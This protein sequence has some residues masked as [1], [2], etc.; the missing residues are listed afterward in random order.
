[1]NPHG[2]L[3]IACA[4]CHSPDAWKPARVAE[5]FRHAPRTFP[6]DGAHARTSCTGCHKKLDFK[7]VSA[8]CASCH[9]DVHKGELGADCARC[10]TP[11]SFAE[12]PAMK[13]AHD[14]TRF[15]LRGAHGGV[16]CSACHTPS[17]SGQL[18]FVGTNTACAACHASDIRAGLV[19]DHLSA[20]FPRDCGACHSSRSWEGARFNHSATRFALTGAHN[21]VPCSGCHTNGAFRGVSVECVS[22]HQADLQSAANPP[23][24]SAIFTAPCTSC[25]STSAWAGAKFNHGLTSFPLTGMHTT[26]PCASCHGDGVYLG[27]A[28]TCVSC[29][30]PDYTQTTNPNHAAA[31]FPTTC[32]G[33]HSTTTWLGAT[34]DHDAR[35]FPIYSGAHRGKWS[36]CAT[37][38]TSPTNYTVF[39]CLTCH[40]HR[41]SDMDAKH[42]NRAGYR[43][44]SQA[45]YAC[46]PRGT[47]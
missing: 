46:H 5:R 32:D 14:L 20:S 25:H 2:S 28:T 9:E 36:S 16:A 47:H 43:Y 29:H 1:M 39:T 42:A 17:R 31:A 40:E 27:K 37:C 23:H 15:P 41:Q 30:Q 18:Q 3:A 33:C 8:R 19:P 45:C 12:E 7:G 34:F 10:H 44:D 26:T 35:L 4:E 6:L 11:R 22:C 38:H 13:Q 24:G 21:A